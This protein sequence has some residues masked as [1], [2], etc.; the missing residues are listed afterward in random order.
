VSAL[1]ASLKKQRRFKIKIESRRQG[2][3]YA[4]SAAVQ[5][6][7]PIWGDGVRN[8][9][10]ENAISSPTGS[11]GGVPAF[12]VTVNDRLQ[13]AERFVTIAH[14][15]GHIFCGHL[16]GCPSATAHDQESGWPNRQSLGPNEKEV[17]AEAVAYLLASRAGILTGSAAYLKTY[18][19]K[20]EVLKLDLDLIVRAAARIER[21]AKIHY[22][23][24]AFKA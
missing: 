5:G 16:G 7:L 9:V 1:A 8:F 15:L 11:D 10:Q 19:G 4:G 20:V 14:E 23:S 24:M 6:S 18:A 3:S 21:L 17:E 22:G 2:F 13:P 12:R